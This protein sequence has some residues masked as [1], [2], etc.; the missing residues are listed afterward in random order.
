M[1]SY[2]DLNV[3][4][5]GKRWLT[6]NEM[7]AWAELHGCLLPTLEHLQ[8]TEEMIQD[9]FTVDHDKLQNEVNDFRYKQDLITSQETHKWL[10]ERVLSLDDLYT[11]IHRKLGNPRRSLRLTVAAWKRR[12]EDPSREVWAELHFSGA[13]SNMVDEFI[14]R[15]AVALQKGILD[16]PP[17]N[18]TPSETS[19][20]FL[21]ESTRHVQVWED[22]YVDY[23]AELADRASCERRLKSHRHELLK[24]KYDAVS[25]KKL[26]AAKEA[27]C[28]IRYDGEAVESLAS[29]TGVPFESEFEF[30]EDLPK[31]L[32]QKLFSAHAQECLEPIRTSPQR[33]YTVYILL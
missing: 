22:A 20:V 17:P 3:F 10:K 31:A 2:G 11:Y 21:N 33:G 5:F 8:F 29:R 28:C 12:C 25:Y 23:C 32:Q 1:E 15:V 7:L 18:G 24:V 30:I 14:C 4:C 13:F 27:Y 26:D 19:Q 9:G 16:N 6:L